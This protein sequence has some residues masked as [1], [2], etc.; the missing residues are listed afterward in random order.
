MAYQ[1]TGKIELVGEIVSKPSNNGGQPFYTREFVL[2][3]TRFNPE[4]GEPWENHPRFELSSKNVNIIDQFHIGQRV[5]VDFTL[6]GAKY[7]DRQSGEIKYF[8]SISAFKI[9][10]AEQQ[11]YNQQGQNAYQQPAQTS[12]QEA[13]DGAPFPQQ[14]NN[15]AQE[16]DDGLPF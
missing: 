13:L 8:T 6:R 4:T 7:P 11:A 9:T 14:N 12:H 10:P 3:A 5:I 16:G 2:D 1:I 15:V